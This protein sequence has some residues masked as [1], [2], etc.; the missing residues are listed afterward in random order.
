MFCSRPSWIPATSQLDA[1]SAP[2][3]FYRDTLT[4]MDSVR[5]GR[6]LGIG[7][8]LAAKT[9]VKAAEAATAPNPN[10]TT[11]RPTPSPSQPKTTV[12]P[13]SLSR[14]A[15]GFRKGFFGT[16]THLGGILWLEVTGFIF[17]VFAFAFAGY[18]FTHRAALHTATATPEDTH[19]LY[20]FSAVAVMF[21]YFAATSFL[22][23]RRRTR[24]ARR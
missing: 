23:A 20:A 15:K 10:P 17:G 2:R 13:A 7:A 12:T 4:H 8:R 3:V 18:A 5:F 11:P 16:A 24:N 9:L 21:G 14:G 22:K 19:R 1:N 6:A